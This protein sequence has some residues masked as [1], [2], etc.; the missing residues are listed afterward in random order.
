[1]LTHPIQ[2]RRYIGFTAS[3]LHQDCPYAYGVMMKYCLIVC[4]QPVSPAFHD[5][6]RGMLQ[7]MPCVGQ[8]LA[9]SLAL[10][11]AASAL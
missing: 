7:P 2:P 1:M 11:A 8:F 4:V 6:E 3:L 9:T 5:L 10:A